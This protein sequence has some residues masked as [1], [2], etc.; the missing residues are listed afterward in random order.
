[1]GKN[2]ERLIALSAIGVLGEMVTFV[3]FVK[4]KQVEP[5]WRAIR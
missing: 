4:G 5:F 3:Y 1:M 2:I